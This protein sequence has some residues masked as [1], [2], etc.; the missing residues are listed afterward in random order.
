LAISICADI[1]PTLDENRIF[2][3]F[4]LKKLNSHPL[5]GIAAMMKIANVDKKE[6]SVTDVVFTLAPRINA[7][8]RIENGKRAVEVL[9]SENVEAAFEGSEQID[10]HN[11]SR[12]ELDKSITE[13]ALQM[14][15]SDPML[16]VRKSTCLYKADWHKGVI[17]IVAS[18]C[19]EHYYRPTIIFTESNGKLAGS[20]RSVKG[21]DVYNAIEACS[22]LIEQFGGHKYAAGLTIKKEN[23][24]AFQQKFEEVVASS[25]AKDLLTPEILLDTEIKLNEINPKF[26]KVLKQFSPCGPGNM[27]PVFATKSVGERGY[28][29]IVGNDH[30]RLEIVDPD[31]PNVFYPAIGFGLG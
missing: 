14:I 4:G 26:Y 1:V 20:A 31:F 21:F 6:L 8:G 13:E 2:T 29:R 7:A 12:R 23:I 24:E 30:L 28:G 10:G 5:P 17:G 11:S 15:G 16:Q 25:I 19:I 22:D 3:Y 27:R 9:I 18:R